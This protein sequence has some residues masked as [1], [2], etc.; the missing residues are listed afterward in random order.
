MEKLP[1]QEGEEEKGKIMIK[2]GTGGWRAVIGDGFTKANIQTIAKAL[3]VIMKK[4]KN[5]QRGVAAG[6]ERRFLSRE[7]VRWVCEVLAY[8]G[9][10]TYVVS[11]SASAALVMFC[12]E[13]QRLPYGFMVTAGHNPDIY[14]GIKIITEGGFEA[15]EIWTERLERIIDQ[16]EEELPVES[17]EYSEAVRRGLIVEVDPCRE[18]RDRVMETVALDVIR[19]RGPRIV[20][21]LAEGERRNCLKEIMNGAGCVLEEVEGDSAKLFGESLT[22]LPAETEALLRDRI[23]SVGGA[24]GVALDCGRGRI[25]V[26][27]DR[28]SYLPPNDVLPLLYYYLLRYRGME[29][30][31][32]RSVAT[33][34]RL[35]RVAAR[36]GEM[37]Y[38]VPVGFQYITAKMREAGAL[39]GGES[40][41]GL[42]VERHLYGK[43]GIYTVVLLAE[44]IAVTGRKL[45]ELRQELCREF[46]PAYL[47]EREYRCSAIHKNRLFHLL[48]EDKELPE[49]QPPVDRV[50]Y[51]DGCKV[52]FKDGGFMLA[53]FSD[54]EPRLLRIFCE[55]A[56]QREAVELCDR[57]EAWLGLLRSGSIN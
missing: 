10:K 18:Y 25:G 29:G 28:G 33:T 41:G 51:L 21:A 23:V 36:F 3:A 4:D 7:A 8:E 1:S 38:E 47:E 15:E 30:P 55:R 57:C 43:D 40:S 48:M 32:V 20:L 22:S 16:V 2:F 54:T 35:D 14:N 46:G 34:H 26:V 39:I 6:G 9:I 13:R 53:R 27:D 44:M 52:Y 19:R 42:A 49:F 12:V 24:F 37:C 11:E 56:D 31:A 45:S 17:M 5:A 50:S